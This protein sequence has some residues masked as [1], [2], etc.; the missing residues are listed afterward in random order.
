MVNV[1]ELTTL[2][3]VL[4]TLKYANCGGPRQ[5]GSAE[6]NSLQM[7]TEILTSIRG[8]DVNYRESKRKVEGL[9]SKP[10]TSY[11]SATKEIGDL[12][13]TIKELMD[14]T[15]ELNNTKKRVAEST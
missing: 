13:K 4:R 14:Q 8:H 1:L 11:A 7:E 15:E 2:P 12:K 3:N 5:S 6:C 9:I 10:N